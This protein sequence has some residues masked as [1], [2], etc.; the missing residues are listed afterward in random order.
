MKVRAMYH[1]KDGGQLAT[2][3]GGGT[4]ASA[5]QGGVGDA[6][7]AVMCRGEGCDGVEG[8]MLCTQA[9]SATSASNRH[10]VCLC[11]H[12]EHTGLSPEHLILLWRHGT[13]TRNVRFRLIP[14][15]AREPSLLSKTGVP[16]FA[17]C[18][19]QFNC[20]RSQFKQPFGRSS[21]LTCCDASV[22]S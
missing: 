4:G 21:H 13:H 18:W 7:D 2:C 12:L 22:Y 20:R 1:V 16:P 14:V 6:L 10:V 8:A 15:M 17:G 3:G 5:F 9:G 19:T 11:L